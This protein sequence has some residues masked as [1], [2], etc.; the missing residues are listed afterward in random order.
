VRSSAKQGRRSAQRSGR[1][2]RSSLAVQGHWPSVV[3]SHWVSS[4]WVTTVRSWSPSR[5]QR[6]AAARRPRRRRSRCRRPRHRRGRRREH[7]TATAGSQ[8]PARRAAHPVAHLLRATQRNRDPSA[9]GPLALSRYDGDDRF[10][11]H[12]RVALSW[13]HGFESRWL[14]RQRRGEPFSGST[15]R[16][17]DGVVRHLTTRAL[18]S[19]PLAGG[20][21]R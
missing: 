21:R 19:T 8:E 15:L 14:R 5:R 18:S 4:T 13:R 12:A 3:V 2:R 16:S 11:H 9:D 7:L 17:P 20:L 10:R 6:R 1:P